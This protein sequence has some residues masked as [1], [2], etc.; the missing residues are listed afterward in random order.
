[1]TVELLREGTEGKEYSCYGVSKY[2][3]KAH[4]LKAYPWHTVLLGGVG[5]FKRWSLVGGFKLLGEV[6]SRDYGTLVS[7]SSFGS[8]VL[9]R[10]IWPHSAAMMCYHATGPKATGPASHELEPTK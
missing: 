5:H 7:S 2:S 9:R 3:P 6:L 10:I 4:V 1:M 8:P